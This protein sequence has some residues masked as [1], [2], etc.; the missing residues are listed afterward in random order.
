[1]IGIKKNL[2][3]RKLEK[4]KPVC[5]LEP[6]N[7][8]K[9]NISHSSARNAGGNKHLRTNKTERWLVRHQPLL[10]IQTLVKRLL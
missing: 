6:Y 7:D 5:G 4:K 10:R 3:L 2:S 1:M 8:Y 9:E